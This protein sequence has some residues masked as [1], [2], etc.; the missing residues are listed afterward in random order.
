M[1][2]LAGEPIVSEGKR[3]ESLLGRYSRDAGGKTG[4]AS[5]VIESV[6]NIQVVNKKLYTKYKFYTDDTKNN[7]PTNSKS[8]ARQK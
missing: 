7:E 4:R 3:N 6:T 1:C 5:D 2:C 8:V